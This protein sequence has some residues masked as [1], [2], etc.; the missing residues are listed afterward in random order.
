MHWVPISLGLCFVSVLPPGPQTH[1]NLPERDPSKAL[2]VFF[3]LTLVSPRPLAGGLLPW[4]RGCPP[5]CSWPLP[6]GHSGR[7]PLSPRGATGDAPGRRSTLLEEENR[8]SHINNIL[9]GSASESLFPEPVFELL[10]RG[11]WPPRSCKVELNQVETFRA[12]LLLPMIHPWMDPARAGAAEVEGTN[13]SWLLSR[14]CLGLE[15]TCR[16]GISPSRPFMINPKFI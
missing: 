13:D 16:M 12:P 4:T 1:K 10:L 6:W 9:N 5:G 15:C 7:K 14:G 11:P 2:P 3:L 8:I